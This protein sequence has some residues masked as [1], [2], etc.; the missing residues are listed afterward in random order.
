MK[1]YF[2]VFCGTNQFF[3]IMKA[4]NIKVRYGA[5]AFYESVKI[6]FASGHRVAT[7]AGAA[8]YAEWL[9]KN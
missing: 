2:D 1:L 8:N 5:K 6:A 9:L 4:I 7:M 3:N